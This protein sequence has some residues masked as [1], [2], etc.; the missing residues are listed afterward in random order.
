MLGPEDTLRSHPK[1]LERLNHRR[2]ARA[3]EAA[4]KFF[5]LGQPAPKNGWYGSQT[6]QHIMEAWTETA[7][8]LGERW[9]VST[10][11]DRRSLHTGDDELRIGQVVEIDG[12]GF[13]RFVTRCSGSPAMYYAHFE[14]Q[15]PVP[16]DRVHWRLVA[17][18]PAGTA[19]ASVVRTPAAVGLWERVRGHPIAAV[20]VFLGAATAGLGR[21][22]DGL[23]KFI[24]F[25]MKY[26]GS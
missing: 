8:V 24:Q 25:L 1:T 2:D 17:S 3:A 9:H 6:W 21:F 22:T 19:P 26:F 18:A 13:R 5:A 7:P 10:N 15:R 20:L 16:V 14:G 4:V 12:E 23:D 11:G